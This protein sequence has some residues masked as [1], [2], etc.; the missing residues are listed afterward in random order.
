MGEN[1]RWWVINQGTGD[2]ETSMGIGRFGDV[3]D[4]DRLK[5]WTLEGGV[6]RIGGVAA[7]VVRHMRVSC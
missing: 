4:E 6:A 1:G 5:C 2:E 3:D 7:S